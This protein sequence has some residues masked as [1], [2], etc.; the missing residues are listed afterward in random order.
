M[1][2]SSWCKTH[3]T[4]K[5]NKYLCFLDTKSSRGACSI[6][7]KLLLPPPAPPLLLILLYFYLSPV[8][9]PEQRALREAR[10][11][12]EQ[13]GRPRRLWRRQRLSQEP[14]G[15]QGPGSHR[16]QARG[17]SDGPAQDGGADALQL[18]LEQEVAVVVVLLASTARGL[19]GLR[20]TGFW[21]YL[22]G[23]GAE[24][25]AAEGAETSKWGLMNGGVRRNSV[26]GGAKRCLM[27]ERNERSR[28]QSLWSVIVWFHT[29][30]A[31]GKHLCYFLNDIVTR[32]GIAS[33]VWYRTLIAIDVMS[34][35]QKQF[36][37]GC[38]IP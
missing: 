29:T 20:C 34:S 7:K 15:K 19:A 33:G 14:P 25:F 3:C 2:G 6:K 11:Q 36:I 17:C 1:P 24:E 22:E 27:N 4:G 28:E 8:R 30:H 5:R 21:G 18:L 32:C 35:R 13:E 9:Q 10:R 12:A 26:A 23:G 38:G 16:K 37:T 31:V